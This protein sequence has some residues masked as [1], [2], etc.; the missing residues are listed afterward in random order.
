MRGKRD[1]FGRERIVIKI[2]QKEEKAPSKLIIENLL[3]VSSAKNFSEAKNEFSIDSIIFEG[4]YGFNFNCQLCHTP[5]LKYNFVMVNQVTGK[6]LNVG[7]TCIIRFNV[8]RG[9]YDVESGTR[10]LQNIADENYYLTHV[11]LLGNVVLK[12]IPH[13]DD[14]R[15]F[16]ES[17]KKIFNL[18]GMKHPDIDQI[19]IVVFSNEWNEKKKSIFNLTR[20]KDLFERPA[21]IPVSHNDSI[22][23]KND[24]IKEGDQIWYKTRRSSAARSTLGRSEQYNIQKYVENKKRKKR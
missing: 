21:Y 1:R 20:L 15:L 16:H 3:N 10:L 2:D 19:G 6:K 12:P 23:F 5:G 14:V 7:S 8:G 17:L 11:R 9:V 18:R 4:S 13:I 24:D 22:K